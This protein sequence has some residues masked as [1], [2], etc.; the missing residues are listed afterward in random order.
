MPSLRWRIVPSGSSSGAAAAYGSLPSAQ[1][2]SSID[3]GARSA[4]GRSSIGTIIAGSR[5]FCT[6]SSVSRSVMAIGL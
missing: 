3:A 6:T 1:S 5:C 4:S 2:V